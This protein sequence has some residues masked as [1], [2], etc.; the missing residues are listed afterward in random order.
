[1]KAESHLLMGRYLAEKYMG[2][3]P[4][5]YVQAFLLG[6]VEPDKNP[7]TYLK[8]S[9]R[10]QWLRGHNFDNSCRY[11]CKLCTQL[12]QKERMKLYDF[13][14]L[15]KL[16]H[17]TADAFTY[18]HNQFYTDSLRRHRDYE[19]QLSDYFRTRLPAQSAVSAPRYTSALQAILGYHR[20]YSAFPMGS[21]TDTRFTVTA[22]SEVLSLLMGQPS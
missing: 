7:A 3:Q 4:R 13:Y 11:M 8:G 19:R 12:G 21:G 18:P 1:M 14:R 10:C 22:C 2:N 16:I 15:G 6:C 5:R 17:Y 20:D 9:L